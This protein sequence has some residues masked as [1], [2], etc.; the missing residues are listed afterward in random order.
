MHRQS[1]LRCVQCGYNLTGLTIGGNCPECGTPIEVSLYRPAPPTSG[2]AI[3]S[4]TLGILSIPSCCCIGI[5]SII[6]GLMAFGFGLGAFAQIKNGDVSQQSRGLAIA[7]L[8]T[9]GIGFLLGAGYWVFVILGN[10]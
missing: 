3:T 5:P 1:Q 8:V 10:I 7:G 2:M 9:G 4:L 6:L